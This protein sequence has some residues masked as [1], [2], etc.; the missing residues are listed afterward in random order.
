MSERY[1]G[2]LEGSSNASGQ[3]ISG[4]C[5][6][7]ILDRT[8][9]LVS[10]LGAEVSTNATK[11][12]ALS[13]RLEQEQF[14]LAVLGQ[15]KRGKS[16]LLNALMEEE[17]LPASVV[18]L[19]AIP[20]FIRYGTEPR[21]R[22]VYENDRPPEEFTPGAGEN[23]TTYLN[24]FVTEKENPEN[25]KGVLQAEVFHSSELLASGLVLIDTPGIGSTFQH[26]TRTTLNFLPQCDAALFLV[27]AD[28][29]V[30]EVEVKFLKEVVTKV[31]RLFFIF[32]KIDYLREKDQE[33]AI[34]FFRTVLTDQTGLGDEVPI[35]PLS[36]LNALEAGVKGDE[37]ALEES[38]IERVRAHLVD[39]LVTEKAR[40]LSDAL[41]GKAADIASSVLMQLNLTAQ[42]LKMPLENL[43]ERLGLLEEKIREA[44]K[45][46]M[47]AGD[48]LAGDRKRTVQFLE[49]LS[50]D[51]RRK[52]FSHFESVIL[53]A[54][55]TS[56][57]GES[58]EKTAR[59]VLTATIPAFFEKE[60]GEVSLKFNSHIADT[61]KPH[62]A[63]ANE[64]MDAIRKG[65]AEL[66]DIPYRA[67]ESEGTFEA[68]RQPYWVTHKWTSSM[69][70]VNAG[71]F[72]WLLIGAL[73]R[74]AIQKRLMAQVEDL[75]IHNVENLRW[76]TL[77]NLDH[78]F[79]KFIANL[80]NGL[81]ET[82][83]ATHGAIEAVLEQRKNHADTI[84]NEL[85]GLES[86]IKA[87]VTLEE[88]LRN[89][90]VHEAS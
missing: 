67:P 72:D 74:A 50:E 45:Q 78:A 66:F 56:R 41:A 61:L 35:F 24:R 82:I 9:S 15:F 14:H 70:P 48:L 73:K 44:E 5:L 18:P 10:S 83:A 69:N 25:R 7:T 88:S 22:I 63:R 20:T 76:A 75:I 49:E 33:T 23:L 71:L 3:P 46:R 2:P 68:T 89:F 17:I 62:Q 13:G 85:A 86:S 27:S 8:I 90:K 1:A 87:M 79:R 28:P 59:D 30:T 64:L 37:T 36:A 65:A 57:S 21:V 43:S 11:L 4:H 58:M 32:N 77:Q 6:E 52:A 53:E 84:A 55:A 16:T 19:T 38:G 34:K 47:S 80:D 54:T 51:L 29:P 26:N 81:T 31:S 12:Q 40:V 39:F 42:S 60:L